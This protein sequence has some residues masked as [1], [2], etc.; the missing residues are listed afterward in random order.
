MRVLYYTSTSFSDCDFPLVK[1]LA[2]KGI[3]VFFLLH[4]A[5]YSVQSPIY[6]I[7]SLKERYGIFPATEYPELYKWREYIDLDKAF[8]ANDPNGK[9]ARIV[10]NLSMLHSIRSFVKK[11]SPDIVHIVEMPFLFQNFIAKGCRVVYTIHDPVPHDGAENAIEEAARCLSVKRGDSFILLNSFQDREF[12]SRYGV[13]KDRLFHSKLGPYECSRNLLTGN[14]PQYKYILFFGRISKYKGIEYAVRAFKTICPRFPDVRFI[15]AGSGSLYFDDD[16]T[17]SPNIIFI[18]KYLDSSEI[19]DLVAG[20]LFVVCPYISATQSGVVQ[21]TYSFSKPVI[22]TSVGNIP[23][24]VEHGKTGLIV[25]P[26][27]AGPLSDAMAELLSSPQTLDAM[28]AEISERAEEG[29]LSW[30]EI[31][32]E[33]CNIYNKISSR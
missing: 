19:A 27:D 6:K 26:G 17:S 24:V 11:V 28:S 9:T 16:I 15:I 10:S 1:A 4:I 2:A 5:P 12:C 22:A 20:C 33:Y 8:I 25:S 13:R 14:S 18:N 3:D 29:A 23:E 7:R 31:A 32:A 30:A 21:T